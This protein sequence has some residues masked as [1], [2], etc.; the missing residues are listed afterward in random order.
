MQV[1]SSETVPY[2]Y[3]YQADIIQQE[4]L[5]ER[6]LRHAQEEPEIV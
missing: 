6:N 1:I 5:P 3:W 4:M 2:Q